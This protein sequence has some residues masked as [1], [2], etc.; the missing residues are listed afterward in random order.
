[1][2]GL[3]LN[4]SKKLNMLCIIVVICSEC[5]LLYALF[6]LQHLGY[7]KKRCSVCKKYNLISLIKTKLL[8]S[9]V[10]VSLCIIQMIT[11][12]KYNDCILNCIF[13]C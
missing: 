9:Y 5:V 2:S 6:V 4:Y 1:M 11:N 8:G 3:F 13:S 12:G 7:R 10:L